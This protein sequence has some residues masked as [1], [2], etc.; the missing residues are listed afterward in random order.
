M[1][2]EDE[3]HAPF[4]PS[5]FL[6]QFRRPS[7]SQAAAVL[8]MTPA[9]GVR[10]G[11]DSE[12]RGQSFL[13]EF[14]PKPSFHSSCMTSEDVQQAPCP[15]SYF[16]SQFRRPTKSQAV[17]SMTPASG[18][19]VGVDSEEGDQSFLGEFPPQPSHTATQR[20][21]VFHGILFRRSRRWRFS[22]SLLSVRRF[23][24]VESHGSTNSSASRR[25]HFHSS[26]MT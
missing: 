10:V 22:R 19:R 16:L 4:P 11:V 3:K 13:G 9:S 14:L 2:S 15:S 5:Y 7:K 25:R 20:S 17:L 8:S 12:E 21:S 26:C 18:V 24:S 6:S 23:T 1:T